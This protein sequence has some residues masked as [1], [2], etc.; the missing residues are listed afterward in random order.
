MSNESN[1]LKKNIA[2]LSKMVTSGIYITDYGG[3]GEVVFDAH[4]KQLSDYQMHM[5]IGALIENLKEFSKTIDDSWTSC[6]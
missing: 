4:G 6:K 5:H 1:H 3:D 2:R